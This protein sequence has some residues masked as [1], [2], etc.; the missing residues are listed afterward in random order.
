MLPTFSFPLTRRSWRNSALVITKTPANLFIGIITNTSLNLESI[1]FYKSLDTTES[2]SIIKNSTFKATLDLSIRPSNFDP[3]LIPKPEWI[4]VPP[5][6]NTDIPV[7]SSKKT[8]GYSGTCGIKFCFFVFWII[9]SWYYAPGVNVNFNLAMRILIVNKSLIKLK[10][11][12][13]N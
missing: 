2:Y 12:L 5:I 9:L 8:L 1:F 4:V 3:G 13:I 7:G 10:K 11:A 6:S